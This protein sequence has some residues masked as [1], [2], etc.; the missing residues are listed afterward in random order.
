MSDRL[1]CSECA[2]AP[3]IAKGLCRKCYEKSRAKIF[4]AI[5]KENQEGFNEIRN[6]MGWPPNQVCNYLIQ[7]GLKRL[8]QRK[9]I[10]KKWDLSINQ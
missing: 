4:I 2:K 6:R 8:A 10:A 1:L 7:Q 3:A 5:S 9:K